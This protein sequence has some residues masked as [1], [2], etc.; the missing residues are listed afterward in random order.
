MKRVL[1]FAFILIIFRLGLAGQSYPYFKYTME[2]GLPSNSTRALFRDSRGWLWI[3]TDAGVCWY[4]GNKFTELDVNRIL[5]GSKVWA[6]AEDEKGRMWFGTYGEGIYIY[7]GKEIKQLSHEN[8]LF[9]D[10]VR[11]L[12][13]FPDYG[14]MIAGG[15]GGI[16]YFRN[17]TLEITRTNILPDESRVMDMLQKDSLIYIFSYGSPNHILDP[18]N[19]SIQELSSS[20]PHAVTSVS[21]ALLTND[22]RLILSRGREGIRIAGKGKIQD[23]G[24]IGQVFGLTEDSQGNI[25]M[26]AWSDRIKMKEPGGIFMFKGDKVIS[27][28]QMIGLPC[29]AWNILYYPEE[30]TIWCTTLDKGLIKIPGMIFSYFD[31]RYFGLDHLEVRDIC[32]DNKKD[33][34]WIA[35]S[36]NVISWSKEGIH[37]IEGNKFIQAGLSYDRNNFAR[38]FSYYLD[39]N[40][41]YQKYD[42]LINLGIYNY[43]NPYGKE[44]K[45]VAAG[46]MYDPDEFKRIKNILYSDT[47]PDEMKRDFKGFDHIQM[48]SKGR[49]LV[50][51][52]MGLFTI[53]PLTYNIE[54]KAYIKGPFALDN[55][56]TL[57]NCDEWALDAIIMPDIDR[58]IKITLDGTD[59]SHPRQCS[60]VISRGNEIWYAGL[61]DGL[62]YSRDGKFIHLNSRNPSLC[63]VINDICFDF[64]GNTIVGANNGEIYILRMTGDSPQIIHRI[65]TKDGI[66]GSTLRFVQPD[67]SGFLWIGTNKGLNRL[68]L[69]KLYDENVVMINFFNDHDGYQ[70]FSGKSAET[71]RNGSIWIGTDKGIVR[72][73]AANCKINKISSPGKIVLTEIDLF[74]SQPDWSDLTYSDLWYNIPENHMN[75]NYDQ[76]SLVFYFNHINLGDPE[77][78]FFSYKLGGLDKTWSIPGSERKAVYSHL[79]PG[80]YILDVKGGNSFSGQELLPLSFQFRISYPWWQTW[81]FYI[82]LSI[83]ILLIIRI[84][85]GY[86]EK[87]IIIIQAQEREIE[88]QLSDMKIKVL[89]SQMNPHFLFNVLNSISSV[90]FKEDKKTAYT[91]FT[92]FSRLIRLTLENA[93]KISRSLKDEIGFA[94]NYLELEQF[95]FQDKFEYRIIIDERVDLQQKVPRMIIHTFVENAVKHGLMPLEYGGLLEIEVMWKPDRLVIVVEDNGIGMD[96]ALKQD[97]DTTRKGLEIIDQMI[98]IYKKLEGIQVSYTLNELINREGISSGTRVEIVIPAQVS[99]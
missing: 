81:W 70:D 44:Y 14:L 11:C 71:D 77:K 99:K 62:F 30:N 19:F 49:L 39:R 93:D 60:K 20:Q 25:W 82:S 83:L 24:N 52:T 1:L 63:N 6:I 38:L 34:I 85:I 29:I 68:D 31:S 27:I 51:S 55:K 88:R 95:R 57:F 7:D 80:S 5:S 54:K 16:T 56:D 61:Y 26:A 28:S 8:G 22:K 17:D 21:S 2:D 42:S 69:K 94:R 65:S 79:K 67:N 59:S 32:Y 33:V 58:D 92:R 78:D 84:Y 89:Q 36:E 18:Q 15:N 4:D 73:D 37:L 87:R 47:Y 74:N 43:T 46:K 53:D 91:Y 76:N 66:I 12:K 86:R 40:G 96:R 50:S 48:D 72:I 9:S 98:A 3:G 23:Y 35:S 13:F 41:S 64:E 45:Q 75:L 10:K 97:K 90:I